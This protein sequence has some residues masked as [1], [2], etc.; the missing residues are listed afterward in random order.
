M[1]RKIMEHIKKFISDSFK[2][3][4]YISIFFIWIN[5]YYSSVITSFIISIILSIITDK[6][7]GLFVNKRNEH[8]I[9]KQEEK[10]KIKQFSMQFLCSTKYQNINYFYSLFKNPTTKKTKSYFVI[11]NTTFVPYYNKKELTEDD[12]IFI[13]KNIPVNTDNLVV[14]CVNAT[15]S[16]TIFAKSI[17][18][19][20][21]VILN[22]NDVYFKFLKPLNALLPN[23]IKFKQSKKLKFKEILTIALNKNT[24]KGY[25]TSGFIILISSIFIK[26]KIYYII[27]ASLLFILS[28][29]SY[30]NVWFNKLENNDFV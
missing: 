5:Y 13:Y 15:N 4:L 18:N 21:F 11:Q 7:I 10:N 30:F 23:S 24:S 6:I 27:F 8:I 9:I 1:Y 26:Y 14:L 22:E 25:F 17:N 12:V 2:Y 28:F 29:I 19:Y 3:T 20:K 16:A